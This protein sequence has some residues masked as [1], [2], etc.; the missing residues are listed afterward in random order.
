MVGLCDLAVCMALA[1]AHKQH[2]VSWST[3][4][5]RVRVQHLPCLSLNQLYQTCSFTGM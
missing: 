4:W 2:P 5:L 3:L 1:A